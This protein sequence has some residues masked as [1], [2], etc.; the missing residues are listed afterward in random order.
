MGLGRMLR[1]NGLALAVALWLANILPAALTLLATTPLALQLN[2]AAL[3]VL[4]CG[5][6]GWYLGGWWQTHNAEN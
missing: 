2:G 4:L 6:C 3:I 1:W 5:F